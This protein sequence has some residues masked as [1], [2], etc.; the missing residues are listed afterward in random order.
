MKLDQLFKALNEY[1]DDLTEAQK[2]DIIDAFC[3][4]TIDA[5]KKD[6]KY[7][8]NML[9]QKLNQYQAQSVDVKMQ[10]FFLALTNVL[11]LAYELSIEAEANGIRKS[12][13][14]SLIRTVEQLKELMNEGDVK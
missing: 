7:N 9:R 11:D 3:Y 10:G 5:L 4:I 8:A 12:F 1:Q 6:D 13:D 2:V 14:A